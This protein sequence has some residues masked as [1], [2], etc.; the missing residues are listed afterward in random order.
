M[1]EIKVNK[2]S[3]ATGTDVTLGDSGDTLTVPSG[4]TI[5]NSGT[6][7]GFGGG[8]VLQF[9]QTLYQTNTSFSSSGSYTYLTGFTL[10]ITPTLNTS[11]IL[12]KNTLSYGGDANNYAAIS[13]YRDIGGGGYS[14][15]AGALGEDTGN[16]RTEATFPMIMYSSGNPT[17]KQFTASSE[18]LDAPATA[19]AVTYRLYYVSNGTIYINYEQLNQDSASRFNCSSSMSAMEL[20]TGVL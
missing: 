18:Y 6:A 17:Y 2:I 14:Q 15:L 11:K 5:V 20:A 4:G 10:T 7:T 8:G 13:I 3:P 19:S 16:S 12:L 1:S 9:K